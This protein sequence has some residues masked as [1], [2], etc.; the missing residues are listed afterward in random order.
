[1]SAV[2]AQSCV[3]IANSETALISPLQ[4]QGQPFRQKDCFPA[5]LSDD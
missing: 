5:I 2:A 4:S 1:M 3:K